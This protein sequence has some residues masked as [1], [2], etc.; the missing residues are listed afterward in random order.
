MS[1]EL[2]GRPCKGK[3]LEYKALKPKHSYGRYISGQ[4]R[5]QTCEIFISREGC[6]D[7]LG[8]A[9]DENT[10][11]LYCNCCNRKVT[12]RP[13]NKKEY[14]K[15][16]ELKQMESF[17]QQKQKSETKQD[18]PQDDLENMPIPKTENAFNEFKEFYQYDDIYEK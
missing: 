15:F 1:D 2:K 16:K 10:E 5:C 17:F 9:A 14:E 3:C 7:K 13:H 11:G 12:G 8:K 18:I 6:H 4:V